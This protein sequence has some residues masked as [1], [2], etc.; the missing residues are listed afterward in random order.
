M[1]FMYDAVATLNEPRSE[2]AQT[3]D[4]KLPLALDT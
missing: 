1:I 2:E 3:F 4:F